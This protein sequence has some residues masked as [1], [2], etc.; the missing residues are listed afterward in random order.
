MA[1]VSVTES[2]LVDCE[3]HVNPLWA[4][5][6]TV[7]QIHLGVHFFWGGFDLKYGTFFF[8]WLYLC[9]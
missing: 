9:M 2:K 8:Y 3:I 6:D 1:Q 4:S 5:T 7:K